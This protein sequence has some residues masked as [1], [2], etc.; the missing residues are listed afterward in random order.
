M[1]FKVFIFISLLFYFAFSKKANEAEILLNIL[2]CFQKNSKV[3]KIIVNSLIYKIYN[4]NPYNIR[5]VYD[6]LQDKLDIVNLCTN[7]LND[8]PSSMEKYIYPYNKQ[9]KEYNWR[10]YL[11]CLYDFVQKESSLNGLIDLIKE[12]N[13]IDAFLK[14]KNLL[15]DG[16]EGILFCGRK[17]EIEINIGHENICSENLFISQKNKFPLLFDS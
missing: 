9:L 5:L 11:D 4:Y 1:I 17:K 14:E 7:N 10:A 3:D 16:S 6:F 13:Y 8:I 12:K 15:K 2:E